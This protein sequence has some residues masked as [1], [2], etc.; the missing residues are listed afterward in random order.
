MRTLVT[1][2]LLVALSFTTK[3][4]INLSI[5]QSGCSNQLNVYATAT[6][7]YATPPGNKWQSSIFA[8]M[9]SSVYG[10]A[11]ISSITP[12]NGFNYAL[13]GTVQT[14]GGGTDFFQAFSFSALNYTFNFTVGQ[15]TLVA[16]IALNG[17]VFADVRIPQSAISG[18]AGLPPK[19]IFQAVTNQH[20]TTYN[21]TWVY[22]IN[23]FPGVFYSASGWC[24]GSGAAG[25]PGPGDV[26]KRCYVKTPG[27]V[28][29]AN[30]VV[31]SLN[32]KPGADVVVNSFFDVFLEIML[33]DNG[34]V[35]G[36]LTINPTGSV[37]AGGPTTMAVASQL[38]IV[39]NASA[40]GS[41]ID[42]GTI[43]YGAAGS[44]TVHT[45]ITNGGAGNYYWHQIGPSVVQTP[46]GNGVALGAFN[47]LDEHTY[48]YF[49]QE[50]TNSWQNFYDLATVIPTTKGFI[51]ST[52]DNTNHTIVMTGQLSTGTI[53]SI[54]IGHSS[55]NL[56]LLSNPYAS[57]IDFDLFYDNNTGMIGNTYYIF[58][59]AIGNYGSYT[60]GI[61]G[62]LT[63][64]VAPGQG[65]FVTTNAAGPVSF[66]NGQRVHATGGLVKDAV[67]YLLQIEAT[68]NTFKDYSYVHFAEGAT[69]EYD[70]F[71]DAYKW[72]SIFPEATEIST[73]SA[74]QQA[75]CMN[76]HPM[77]GGDMVS[78]PMTFKCGVDG[79]Y[80]ITASGMETFD[81]GTEIYLEDLVTGA[82]WVDLVA[83][84]VYEFTG[85]PSDD[86]GRFIIHFFGPTGIGENE[87]SM[88]RI[89]GWGQDAYIVNRGNET[90]KEYVA[91]DLMGR[92]LHR[93]TLPNN[94]VNKVTIG[95][96]SAYYIVKV[97]T[98][99]GRIY[100]DKVYIT[101]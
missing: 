16:I 6:T 32:V 33:E 9:W 83:N 24:G 30:A 34:T 57:C 22:G 3:A 97:I 70:V 82:A 31:K 74:D 58:N 93:G 15:K 25:A 55:G 46:P 28:I 5:E 45:Y 76:S 71:F 42:N 85:T 60:S 47:I 56:E 53:A 98:K 14:Y 50:S 26:A 38:Y 72:A 69:H 18:G 48:A 11:I 41:F 92:E 12:Q 13:S 99:E 17:D 65:F 100:T 68:G 79:L 81:L 1:I 75:L 61:G 44:A 27:A 95:D 20:P 36:T 54:P 43:V 63:D 73:I 94:T 10:N 2:I 84:P 39:A 19:C 59:P 96:V 49:Y 64:K 7:A 101:K 8:V 29:S 4:A 67:P 21:A 87:A 80:T 90:I 51:I 78:V 52:D 40:H 37:T 77:L 62:D 91:Y 86:Q 89:Y 35:P 66:Q 23:L 88:V